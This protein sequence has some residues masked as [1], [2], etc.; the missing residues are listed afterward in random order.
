MKIYIKF[1]VSLRCKLIVKEILDNLKIDYT[2]IELGMV[3]CKDKIDAD[4]LSYFDKAIRVYG[5]EVLDDSKAILVDRIK[6]LIIELVH[7]TDEM[8][9]VKYSVFIS[10]HLGY[11]YTY[12]ASLFSEVKG[13][14]IEQFIISH[15]IERVKELIIYNEL[16][17]TEISY[18]LNYSSVA[19]LSKQFTKVTGLTPTF[20]KQLK[21]KKRTNLED[22]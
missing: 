7:Y 12:L 22:I 21:V 17:L 1:M 6:S 5:L 19:H 10:E 9:N 8:P 11:N 3:E 16:S 2:T 13:V 15:K 14:T 18:L 20:F 4:T